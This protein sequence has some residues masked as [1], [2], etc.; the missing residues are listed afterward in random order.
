MSETNNNRWPH[1]LQVFRAAKDEYGDPVLDDNGDPT[2]EAVTL[3]VVEYDG[4]LPKRDANGQFL[5][6]EVTEI[7]Y[8][9]RITVKSTLESG[10]ADVAQFHISLPLFLTPLYGGDDLVL[11]DWDRTYKGVVVRKQNSNF[12]SDIWYNEVRN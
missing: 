2:L 3:S 5:T 12:G 7:N 10:D 6:Q 11:K 1:T 4:N 8:G 9:Y